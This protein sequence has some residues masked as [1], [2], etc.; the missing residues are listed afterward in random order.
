VKA[1]DSASFG[2]RPE[3]VKAWIS[4]TYALRDLE[5]HGHPPVCQ[6]PD[7]DYWFSDS[8]DERAEAAAACRLS[9]C[10]VLPLCDRF[11]TENRER[12]GVWAG[13]SRDPRDRRKES[14]Q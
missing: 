2:I 10:P 6:G 13:I 1:G 12:L 5:D 3:A 4:L 14:N 7:R 8:R 11:A 9:Q